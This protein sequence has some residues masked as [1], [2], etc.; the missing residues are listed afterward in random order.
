MVQ[1]LELMYWERKSYS[2]RKQSGEP[3]QANGAKDT[4]EFTEIIV[5]FILDIV[6]PDKV[7]NE[8]HNFPHNYE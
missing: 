3:E 1:L 4:K 5:A 6:V 7:E 8:K 2:M